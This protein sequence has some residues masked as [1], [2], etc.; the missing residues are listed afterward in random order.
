LS[1]YDISVKIFQKII[2][3]KSN[4]YLYFSEFVFFT[5]DMKRVILKNKAI[6]I[7]KE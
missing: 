3:I 2:V 6:K 7:K 1:K 5:K 4:K